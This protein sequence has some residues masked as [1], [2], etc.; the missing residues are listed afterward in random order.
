M[1]EDVHQ[2]NEGNEERNYRQK[3][4]AGREQ[5]YQNQ[6]DFGGGSQ[7]SFL[8][9]SGFQMKTYECLEAPQDAEA[10]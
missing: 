7:V 9:V 4:C 3:S 8:N 10:D 5:R 6:A 2:A 1:V